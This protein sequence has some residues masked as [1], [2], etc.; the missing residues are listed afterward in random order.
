M[1]KLLFSLRGVSV[2][3]A[4]E[5]QMLLQ[6]H[7]IEFYATTAGSWGIATPALWLRHDED[8]ARAR[9]LIDEYEERRAKEQK[10]LYASLREQG[11]HKTFLHVVKEAPVRVLL[12]VGFALF[13]LYVSIMPFFDWQ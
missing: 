12:Y 6:A 7:H 2:E 13:L 5:V 1:A 10:A 9:E 3:E 11:R 4:Q 8:L